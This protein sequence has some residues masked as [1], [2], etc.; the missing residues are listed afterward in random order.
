[1]GEKQNEK[2]GILLLHV[3][4]EYE[5]IKGIK[6]I[7]LPVGFGWAP[8]RHF[9]ARISYNN[10]DHAVILKRCWGNEAYE[11]ERYAYEA[12]MPSI[13]FKTAAFFGAITIGDEHWILIEDIG[14]ECAQV[15]NQY[16]RKEFLKMLGQLHGKSLL[17]IE[18]MGGRMLLRKF[19]D[20]ID[21][22]NEKVGLLMKA[23]STRNIWIDKWILNLNEIVWKE[24][25][26]EI[27]TIVHGDTDF[28]N[29]IKT[30]KGFGIIDF[31][32]CKIG[33]ASI[34]FSKIAEYIVCDDEYEVYRKAFTQESKINVSI[35]KVLR[36]VRLGAAYD[37]I[38]W[39]CYDIKNFLNPTYEGYVFD[40]D[41]YKEKVSRLE[42]LSDM[43]FRCKV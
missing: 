21:E 6:F 3:V 32:R 29:V 14:S 15:H 5:N 11:T 31:E 42:K 37:G 19:I 35:E 4:N 28:S 16:E 9:H 7:S 23:N 8:E 33:P 41:A 26:T 1:M 22:Y 12:I 38:H 18:Q 34:D 24:L 13:P 43:Y 10:E 40:N 39:I 25:I 27:Q 20:N 2:V 30:E 36:W 17:L